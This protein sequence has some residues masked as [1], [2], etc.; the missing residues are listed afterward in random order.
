MALQAAALQRWSSSALKSPRG[1]AKLVTGP[2]FLTRRTQL[3]AGREFSAT[4]VQRSSAHCHSVS[5]MITRRGASSLVAS[6][7]TLPRLAPWAWAGLVVT[8]KL[9][10][11][12]TRARLA[13]RRVRENDWIANV[14]SI[15]LWVRHAGIETVWRGVD[16]FTL[17]ITTYPDRF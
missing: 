13:A 7:A 4:E 15:P 6:E 16:R 11:V 1:V 12:P 2:I 10:M 17:R 3:L 8:P 9:A 14:M 5:L